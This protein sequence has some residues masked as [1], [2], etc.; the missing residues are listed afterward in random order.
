M[1][2]RGLTRL[3]RRIAR[4]VLRIA[5]PDDF[6]LA[7]G[8]AL[9]ASHLINRPT[10]DIDVLTALDTDVPAVARRVAY[11]LRDDGLDVVVIANSPAFARLEV[12]A[13]DARRGRFGVDLGR[14]RI[15]WPGTT[16]SLGP[17]LSPRELA[18]N[19]VLALAG[20]VQP[21]DLADVAAL[22]E[23]V[24][25]DGMLADAKV[26]DRGFTTRSLAEMIRMVVARPDA[27]WPVGVDVAAVRSFGLDLAKRLED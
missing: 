3:Q 6:H 7:G 15:E 24:T 19:K 9:V 16:T 25:L 5:A 27:Q 10:R 26:K 12:I 11:A 21:R 4:T 20:R 8:A 13:E 1:T 17:T 18:A 2:P 14:D 23:H 22:V